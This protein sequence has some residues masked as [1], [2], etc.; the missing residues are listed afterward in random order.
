MQN[1]ERILKAL[2][3][4]HRCK[5]VLAAGIVNPM[6]PTLSGLL[7][8]ASKGD[9]RLGSL[10]LQSQPIRTGTHQ[11]ASGETGRGSLAK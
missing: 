3:R 8:L 11:I 4:S 6:G 7:L 2:R 5:L 9:A 10:S 1:N